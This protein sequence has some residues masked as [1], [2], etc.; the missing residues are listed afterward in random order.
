MSQ[1]KL[2]KVL[3]APHVSEKSTVAADSSNQFVFKVTRDASK[4]DVKNAVELMFEVKVDSVNL[5]NVKGKTK[6]R[7]S[8]NKGRRAHWKKAYVR[9]AEGF[10]IDYM[11][12]E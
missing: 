4:A 8:G 12:A 11:G 1:E 10:D 5:M 6:G 2:M 9:L 7:F 3:V